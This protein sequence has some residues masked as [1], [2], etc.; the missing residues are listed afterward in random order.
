MSNDGNYRFVCPECAES[1]TV[2]AEVRDA[3]AARGCALCGTS[4][5]ADA[6]DSL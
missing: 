5:S 1:M 2:T 6:F 3:L 4:V